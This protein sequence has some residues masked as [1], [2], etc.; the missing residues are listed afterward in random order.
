MRKEIP[1]SYFV[2]NTFPL[3]RM[4]AVTYNTKSLPCLKGGDHDTTYKASLV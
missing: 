3:K 4:T 1:F 2:I